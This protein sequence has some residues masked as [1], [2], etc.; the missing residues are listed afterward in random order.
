[1]TTVV[2]VEYFHVVVAGRSMATDHDIDCATKRWP[3]AEG[4]SACSRCY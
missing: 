1:M 3:S 4:R 2:L